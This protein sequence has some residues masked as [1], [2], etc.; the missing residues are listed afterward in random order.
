MASWQFA[1]VALSI[2][3]GANEAWNV[4]MQNAKSAHD[5]AFVF[6]EQCILSVGINPPAAKE[7]VSQE[8]RLRHS[9]MAGDLADVI[10]AAAPPITIACLVAWV[11]G[12]FTNRRPRGNSN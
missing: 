9:L 2:V 1:V 6:G 8:I 12:W 7:C 11:L 5:T 3:Y 10:R 4:H